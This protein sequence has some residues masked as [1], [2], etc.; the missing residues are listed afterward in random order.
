MKSIAISATKAFR[1]QH[2]PEFTMLEFYQAYTD[3]HGLMD[4]T[5]EL[6]KQT[7]IDATGSAVV[8]YQGTKLDF[9]NVRR[10]SMQE[11][12]GDDL[13]ARACSGGGVRAAGGTDA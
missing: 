2:N 11:A 4:L 7:A 3:Y 5:V 6:L 9:G 10:L 8:E 1:L 12:V 13:S